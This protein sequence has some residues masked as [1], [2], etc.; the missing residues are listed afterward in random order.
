MQDDY[1]IPN[2]ASELSDQ[3]RAEHEFIGQLLSDEEIMSIA[4]ACKRIEDVVPAQWYFARAKQEGTPQTL[5]LLNELVEDKLEIARV[6]LGVPEFVFYSQT[7]S[8]A[9]PSS[10][11]TRSGASSLRD[12]INTLHR[13]RI[14]KMDAI[15]ESIQEL[16]RQVKELNSSI[17]Y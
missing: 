12:D 5:D 15:I 14:E 8:R 11:G 17:K 16:S 4:L 13:S 9:G 2:D 1:D 7:E 3:E 10:C 6:R